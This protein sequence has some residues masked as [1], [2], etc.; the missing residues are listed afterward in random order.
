MNVAKLLAS[1]KG[2]G[3]F[4][5][6]LTASPIDR[7]R[8]QWAHGLLNKTEMLPA[9][10]KSGTRLWRLLLSANYVK[11]PAWFCRG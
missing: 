8:R 9:I 1:Y 5:H 11:T 7:N 6:W 3:S 4:C 2:R 10:Q